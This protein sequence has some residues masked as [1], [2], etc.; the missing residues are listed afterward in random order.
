MNKEELMIQKR[1][2]ELSNIA[3]RRDIVTFSDFLNLNELN[4]LHDAEMPMV[5]YNTFKKLG[6]DDFTIRINNRKILNGFFTSLNLQDPAEVLRIIDKLDK[7]GID[8]IK[9][10]LSEIGISS[11]SAICIQSAVPI[12]RSGYKQ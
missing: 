4:I 12:C 2:I 7:I 5:I 3:Y 9:N 10:C 6:F 1:L 8:E 11:D